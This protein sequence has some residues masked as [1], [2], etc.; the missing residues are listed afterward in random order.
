ME[1]RQN[2]CH[3]QDRNFLI[4]KKKLVLNLLKL[5]C[6]PIRPRLTIAKNRSHSKLKTRVASIGPG[7]QIVVPPL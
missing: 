6:K 4:W 2:F 7:L 1:P 3:A 5:H